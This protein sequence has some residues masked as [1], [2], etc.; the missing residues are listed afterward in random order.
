MHCKALAGLLLLLASPAA[1]EAGRQLRAAE[2]PAQAD[3]GAADRV[4]LWKKGETAYW[5]QTGQQGKVLWDG[6]HKGFDY[7]K[8]VWT[9]GAAK[10]KQSD[11]LPYAEVS[12][13]P[14]P[15]EE[16]ESYKKVKALKKHLHLR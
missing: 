3:A 4:G 11:V 9:A 2:G 10:G 13:E 12:R 6:R 5:R 1:A 16:T 15:E 7:V 14:V 8:L